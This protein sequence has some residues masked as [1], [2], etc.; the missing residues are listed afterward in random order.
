MTPLADG[1]HWPAVAGLLASVPVALRPRADPS[2][3]DPAPD[4][5]PAGV[6]HKVTAVY[7]ALVSV[8]LQQPRS[9]LRSH[10]P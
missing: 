3:G 9:A 8:L 1:L 10:M 4:V 7:V 5:D 6:E 2:V